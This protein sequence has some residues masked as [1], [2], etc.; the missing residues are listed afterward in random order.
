MAARDLE[1]ALAALEREQELSVL[2]RDRALGGERRHQRDGAVV[3][4]LDRLAPQHDHADDLVA[5]QHRHA[6]HRAE[7]AEL[8]RSVQL[9][10]GIGEHVEDLHGLALEA[11]AAD[12]RAGAA[13]QRDAGDVV[14]VRLRA[15]DRERDAVLV[16]VEDVDQSGV[17]AAEPHGLLQHRLEDGFELGRR[18][19]DDLEHR[20]GRRLL[21]ERVGQVALEVLDPGAVGHPGRA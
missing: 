15:A 4:R 1:L 2:D 3:E 13:L 7:A 12:E 9:V 16:T 11:D 14:A 19:P 17:R 21:L 5:G 6:A 18:A 20:P 8:A 10:L